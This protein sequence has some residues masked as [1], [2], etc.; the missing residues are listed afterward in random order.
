MPNSAIIIRRSV[1]VSRSVINYGGRL[2]TTPSLRSIISVSVRRFSGPNQSGGGRKGVKD[3]SKFSR[4]ERRDLERQQKRAEKRARLEKSKQR[5]TDTQTKSEHLQ[6]ASS[7]TSSRVLEKLK[8]TFRP[9]L[10]GNVIL[11]PAHMKALAFRIPIF[12]LLCYGLTSEDICPIAIQG[13]LGPSMIPTMQF[14]GDY[15]LVTTG[16]WHRLVGISPTYEVGDIVIWKNPKNEKA[17]CKRIVGLG[18]NEVKRYGQ[19]VNLYRDRD[20]LGIVW[21]QQSSRSE[22]EIVPGWDDNHAVKGN[23]KDEHSRT[24]I[25]PSGHI[26]LE[27]DAPEFS[28]DSRQTGPVPL[29]WI[30]GRVLMRIWPLFREDFVDGKVYPC[31]V[32]RERP[33]PFSSTEAYLGK[34]FN[35][36]KLRTASAAQSKTTPEDGL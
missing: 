13:G 20:D 15:W 1:P 36:Y 16:A 29:D 14:F 22:V 9:K 11:T 18:G 19:H 30:R 25:V 31:T 32:T 5:R 24:I 2:I 33:V 17:S 23:E 10:P 6:S 8:N 7:N 4:K 27:G 34:R 21:P 28:V 12:F 3:L 26:W 35:F